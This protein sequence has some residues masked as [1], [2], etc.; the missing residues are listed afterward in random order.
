MTKRAAVTMTTMIVS[1]LRLIQDNTNASEP[2]L[3]VILVA[4]EDLLA[5]IFGASGTEDQAHV[6]E[7]LGIYWEDLTVYGKGAGESYFKTV[8][9]LFDPILHPARIF[10]KSAKEAR[11][12][13][14]T[15]IDGFTGVVRPGEMCL[16]LGRPGSG[17]TTLLKVLAGYDAGFE[18]I[19]GEVKFGD[20][21]MEKMK[22]RYRGEVAFNG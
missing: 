16:V 9:S 8:G 22:K 18:Q 20:I 19:D 1:R 11:S 17:C 13:K 3:F 4:T 10:S 12:G 6:K 5:Q 15:L 21:S 7:S 2:A 14:R